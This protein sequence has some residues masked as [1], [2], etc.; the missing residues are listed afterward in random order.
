MRTSCGL[1]DRSIRDLS[2]CLALA[3][4]ASNA[5]AQLARLVEAPARSPAGAGGASGIGTGDGGVAG[6]G[7]RRSLGCNL[8]VDD[9]TAETS[10]GWE[11]G[12]TF[13][14]LNSLEASP[15]CERIGE[16]WVVW[17]S[18]NATTLP[19]NNAPAYVYIWEDPND[20]GNPDDAEL[21]MAQ[22]VLTS[23]VATGLEVR[24]SVPL[25]TVSGK[26]FVGAS[27]E[28]GPF[29]TVAPLDSTSPAVSPPVSWLSGAIGVPFDPALL[30][31]E[32]YPADLLANFGFPGEWVIRAVGGDTGYVYQ[33]LLEE[34]GVPIDGQVDLSFSLFDEPING[35][36]IETR[37]VLGVTVEDGLF[38]TPVGF[39]ESA[40]T[41]VDLWMEISVAN[42]S[43]S[44]PVAL[45]G[46]QR[47]TAAPM[48]THAMEAD[49]ALFAASA[50]SA[51]TAA[52]YSGTLPW[53]RLTSV[54]AGFADGIDDV[55]SGA[56]DGHSLDAADGSPTDAVFVDN[57]GRVGINL[58]APP[59]PQGRLHVRGGS[60]GDHPVIIERAGGGGTLVQFRL[61]GTNVGEIT[62]GGGGTITY[63]SFTGVHLA[64]AT[65]P[66]E[67]ATLVR[68]SGD[69][70]RV[71]DDPSSEIIYGVQPTT[72]ANDPAVIGCFLASGGTSNS[73]RDSVMSVGNG[74]MWVVQ[75]TR[76]I[77]PGDLL[78]ASDVAGCA[79]LDD[80]ARFARGNVV[81]RAAEP[82]DWSRIAPEPDGTRRALVSVLFDRFER[83]PD[84]GSLQQ[85]IDT[86]DA[87][88]RA[89]R[90]RLDAL[91]AML[92]NPERKAGGQ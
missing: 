73:G 83:G 14:W 53:N 28:V 71:S 59:S 9:G 88:N 22:E 23:L 8:G 82:V 90:A 39:S 37:S 79:M 72:I 66:L 7:G 36:L 84:T 33:G 4:F 70:A 47:I 12:G 55:G 69:N 86:L 2:L 87:E 46:R 20:D 34:A 16:I 27:M 63:G 56:G 60:G 30:G 50:G 25:T 35:S 38:M 6:A 41:G 18:S 80:P 1:I 91:E 48:A 52:N 65:Q 58:P 77:M 76:G 44:T 85:R 32:E 31:R 24:Y 29:V 49:S 17:S 64:E 75:T 45:E 81:A 74:E 51:N 68:L 89:L 92:Q 3:M 11:S 40:F 67:H 61:D 43:G 15:G 5:A 57:T 54:P 26:F 78:I 62:V 42:P 21:L 19:P 10:I 13:V